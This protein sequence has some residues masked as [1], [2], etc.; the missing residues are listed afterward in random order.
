M[1]AVK[2]VKEE[3]KKLEGMSRSD[4]SAM[5]AAELV[6][7]R[8]DSFITNTG[9]Y[10]KKLLKWANQYRGI[11]GDKSYEG[12]ANVFVKETLQAVESIVAQEFNMI[13]SESKPIY[14]KGREETDE[15][16][17]KLIEGMTIASLEQMSNKIKILQQLRQRAKYGTTVAEVCWKYEY[18]DVIQRNPKT[19]TEDFVSKV[20]YDNPDLRY[21]DLLDVAF[22]PGKCRVSDMGWV[23]IRDRCTWDDLKSME[24][25]VRVINGKPMM[26]GIYGNLDKVKS[27]GKGKY[28]SSET[29]DKKQRF[30]SMG[31]TYDQ[32][33]DTQYEKLKMYGRVP[34]WWLD[35]NVPLDSDDAE[36]MIQGVIEVINGKCTIRMHRNPYYHQEIPILLDQFIQVD[37]D[38]FGIGV[39]EISE[40]LQDEL[41]CKRNQLL[42]HAGLTIMPPIIK[43]S[44]S[45]IKNEQIQYRARKIITSNLPP[46]L[47]IKPLQ[48][49][50][51]PAE[52]IS[53]ESIIKQDIR[54]ESGAS[55][56]IQGI[57]SGGDT[58]ATEINILEKRGASR[59]TVSVNSFCENFIKPEYRFIYKL[60]QQYVDKER[61]VQTLGK[62][63]IK[64]DKVTPEMLILDLDLI[65]KVATDGDSRIL[66]RNQLIQFLQA[67]AKYYPETKAFR[68]VRKVYTMFGFDDVD[69]TV[70]MPQTEL[71]KDDITTNEEM[72][73]LSMGQMIPVKFYEDHVSKLD[74]AKIVFESHGQGMSPLAQEAFK[75]YM[76][77][78]AHYLKVMERE[79]ET[80]MAQVGQEG[81]SGGAS[82]NVQD[83]GKTQD[84]AGMMSKILS[85]IRG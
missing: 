36:E 35:D 60:L 33:D 73:V 27:L 14:V 8:W 13:Y 2:D 81:A 30:E 63:G 85:A 34:R 24:M 79:K 28:N 70:P 71:G 18:R 46:D 12:N 31:I 29:N 68:L 55:N 56:P 45:G 61:A 32:L 72:I 58:T 43:N 69:E 54:N 64:W 38:A 74:A 47:S 41:N 15:F 42:D 77:Q 80:M 75:D 17:A 82:R 44:G 83:V 26:R 51:N 78:H 50:G 48:I 39:C 3:A 16:K 11:P 52:I 84:K 49:G 21:I 40:D 37:N 23:I 67:V 59:I 22:D 25:K 57:Q 19:G 10:R 6:S 20:L 65:P 5:Q 62:D 66:V 4:L 7:N 76:Q 9:P 1:E 53:M